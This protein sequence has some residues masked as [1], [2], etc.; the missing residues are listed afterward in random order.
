MA[1]GGPARLQRAD[2]MIDIELV[3]YS[4]QCRGGEEPENVVRTTVFC[5]RNEANSSHE[6]D[7]LFDT[8]SI[9]SNTVTCEW[10][11][12]SFILTED[13][14]SRQKRRMHQQGYAKGYTMTLSN[15]RPKSEASFTSYVDLD[16][17]PAQD[18][19]VGVL[20]DLLHGEL[21]VSQADRV[22]CYNSMSGMTSGVTGSLFVTTLKL[23][24]KLH[25]ED[26]ERLKRNKILA[27]FDI[28]LSS[29]FAI[30]EV[31]GGDT[32]EKK[33]KLLFGSNISNRIDG[34]FI[35]CKNFKFFRFSFKFSGVDQGRNVVNA[36]LH[37]VRP[38]KNDLLFAFE[39]CVYKPLV[40]DLPVG[41]VWEDVRTRSG[42]PNT[43]ICRANESWQISS[44]LPQHFVIPGHMSDSQLRTVS[45]LFPANRPPVWTWGTPAG[46]AIFIQPALNVLLS[47]QVE[48]QLSEFYAEGR[49]G[50]A[51]TVLELDRMLPSQ[52]QLEDAFLQLLELHCVETEKEAEQMDS[53]YFSR[54]ENSG[55]LSAV[56]SVLR[57]GGEVCEA[58]SE[59]RCV[60]LVEGE[61]RTTSILVAS[62]AEVML[63]EDFRSRKGLESLIQKNWV[64]LGFPFSRRHQLCS[65]MGEAG[66][67]GPEFF[68]FLDAIFQLTQQFPAHFEFVPE[69]L[70]AVWDTSLLPVFDTF[71]F[72]SEHDRAMAR[73]SP[74]TPLQLS[75]AWAW[76]TQFST[77][78]I[79]SLRNPLYGIP[80]RPERNG[81]RHSAAN[82][83]MLI[84]T[85]FIPSVPGNNQP[86]PVRWEVP[87]LHIWLDMFHRSVNFF[88]ILGHYKK[89][90]RRQQEEALMVVSLAPKESSKGQVKKVAGNRLQERL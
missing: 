13:E 28:P 72:D 54:L 27:A 36:L 42:C 17:D 20:P 66:G 81:T 33:K 53:T 80:R 60:S 11:E 31:S 74:D 35:L 41:T 26:E 2:S 3:T 59:G 4:V 69:Y 45:E 64:S 63:D 85:R 67:V 48:R 84:G 12:G 89:E 82:L 79:Q 7:D 58:I 34:V 83:S 23:S 62:L 86:L 78:F 18:E 15:S 65:R 32:S 24:L 22:C 25:I 75:S 44:S 39:H 88:Q 10:R 52:V 56:S 8:T 38:K 71:I 1:V 5:S 21:L 37:H 46:A 76:E 19:C 14:P 55:W 50:R 9:D 16:T 47:P 51:R 29:I 49:A 87:Q 61:G 70:T 90:L 73:T 40:G 68:L 77:A 57:C 6:E 30:Y 43:R